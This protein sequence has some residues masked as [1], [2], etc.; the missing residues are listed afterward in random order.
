M[1]PRNYHEIHSSEASSLDDVGLTKLFHT[2]SRA[3]AMPLRLSADALY[4]LHGEQATQQTVPCIDCALLSRTL[5][6]ETARWL[7]KN[8]VCG[9]VLLKPAKVVAAARM[10]LPSGPASHAYTLHSE[11][12]PSC[13]APLRVADL[14][15]SHISFSSST[16]RSPGILHQAACWLQHASLLACHLALAACSPGHHTS[17]LL[18]IPPRP[19][20]VSWR[21]QM[22]PAPSREGLRQ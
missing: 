18:R 14:Q 17:E 15:I 6:N 9:T 20:M 13:R 3:L 2:C 16:R 12:T 21:A 7:C 8:I 1:F 5:H 22:T 10:A 4:R 19:T 11:N